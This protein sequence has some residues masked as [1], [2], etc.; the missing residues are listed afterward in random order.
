MAL[1]LDYTHQNMADRLDCSFPPATWLETVCVYYPSAY[2]L[3]AVAKNRESVPADPSQLPHAHPTFHSAF[4]AYA[5]ALSA[6]PWL[7]RFPM[8]IAN[9][10]P[11]YENGA[12]FLIT[13]NGDAL[14]VAGLEIMSLGRLLAVSGGAPITIFGE[15]NG[16]TF[17]P[18]S[19]FAQERLVIL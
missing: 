4:S 18:L 19:V 8:L 12:L 5:A 15:Y 6:N 16:R 11:F 7:E 14:S 10:T 9:L 13:P 3:R 1:L 17:L 2:P